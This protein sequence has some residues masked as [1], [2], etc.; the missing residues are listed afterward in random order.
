[1]KSIL[2]AIYRFIENIHNYVLIFAA[3]LGFIEMYQPLWGLN[4]KGGRDCSDR[5]K[6]IEKELPEK[7]FSFLDTGCQLGFFTMSAANKGAMAFGVERVP[8]FFKLATAVRDLNKM[9][10]ASYFNMEVNETTVKKFPSVDVICCMSIYH[11]WV[12]DWGYE[13]ADKMFTELCA[14]TK[15]IIFETG[16][17]NETSEEFSKHMQFMGDDPVN[18]CELYLKAKGFNVVKQLGEFDTHLSPVK[19]TLFFAKKE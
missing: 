16:Q 14:K 7:H 6:V 11:H 18:W 17:S 9:Y 12:A 4:S 5:W 15:S 10:N 2:K 19:R 3:E 8:A 13:G 1:M